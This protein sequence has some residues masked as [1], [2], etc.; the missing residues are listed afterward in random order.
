MRPKSDDTRHGTG[1]RPF[2]CLMALFLAAWTGCEKNAPKT[3]ANPR[4]ANVLVLAAAT[5]VPPYSYRDPATGEYRGIDI[6]IAQAAAKKMGLGLEIRSMPFAALFPALKAGAA[7]FA[8]GAITITEGRSRDVAF[9]IPYATDGAAFLYRI[10]ERPPTMI[11]AESLR[12]A[13]IDSMTHDFYLTRHGIDPFRYPIFEEAVGA[14]VSGK[15]DTVFFERSSVLR[16]ARASN[17]EFAVTPLEMREHFGIAIRK[18]LP[19]LKAA[20]DAAIKE[21]GAR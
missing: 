13:A 4:P 8:A 3:Q 21:R 19:E 6:E 16:M 7:D 12:V 18:D 5:E 14:L 9:S 10:G 1:I 20:V 11:T 15:V 17:G 2:S